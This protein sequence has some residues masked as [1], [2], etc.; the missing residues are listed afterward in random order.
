MAATAGDADNA[1]PPHGNPDNDGG[2]GGDNGDSDDGDGGDDDDDDDGPGGDGGGAPPPPLAGV[3]P[4]PPL[5][6]S[7]A[8]PGAPLGYGSNL[9]AGTTIPRNTWR[10]KT[11]ALLY[12]LNIALRSN[13]MPLAASLLNEFL[14]RGPQKLI[15][16]KT[17]GRIPIMGASY[18]TILTAVHE[19]VPG[20]DVASAA[21][22]AADDGNI[23]GPPADPERALLEKA[24]HLLMQSDYAGATKLLIHG[25]QLPFDLTSTSGR[26]A[27]DA[28]HPLQGNNDGLSSTADFN[29][30][31]DSHPGGQLTAE[32]CDFDEEHLKALGITIPPGDP[33]T[34]QRRLAVAICPLLHRLITSHKGSKGRCL[35]GWNYEAL[36]ALFRANDEATDYTRYLPLADLLLFIIAGKLSGPLFHD[37]FSISR[38]TALRKPTGKPRPI[39]MLEL[40]VRLAGGLAGRLFRDKMQAQLAPS[41]LGSEPGGC[42]AIAHYLNYY[43]HYLRANPDHVIILKDMTNALNCIDTQEILNCGK[44]VYRIL[45]IR[46]S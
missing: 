7:C 6:G 13:D 35:S 34:F 2:D 14:A 23:G 30:P 36:L 18:Q 16:N 19:F 28:L 26:A 10:L 8:I 5:H 17:N 25:P 42:E 12:Q 3:P 37:F 29:L 1:E 46:H 27:I 31:P 38:N 41:D 24:I 44:S 43:W 21:Q 15:D 40:L 4:K 39:G 20:D 11:E 22:A 9:P 32:S 33:D 45:C